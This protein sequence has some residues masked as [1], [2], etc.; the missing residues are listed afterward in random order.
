MVDHDIPGDRYKNNPALSAPAKP[1][2]W[3][4]SP[5]DQNGRYENLNHPYLPSW[6]DVFKWKFQKSP[7]RNVKDIEEWNPTV[8]ENSAWLSGDDD[9]MVWL[10]HSTFYIRLNG[11]RLITDPVFYNILSVKRK[12]RIP[13]DPDLLSG[14]DYILLSHDHRDHLDERS[15]KLV[16]KNNPDVTYLAGLSMQN[17][18]KEFTASEKIQEAGWYQRYSIQEELKI[19]FIPSRHWSKR[20]IFDTNSRLWG[21]FVLEKAGLRLLFGGDSGYDTHYGQLGAVFGEFDYAILGVGAYEP[22]WFMHPNHQSP[23]EA[24]QGFKDLR[25]KRFIP[26]HYGTFDLSDEP[27]GQPL[28]DLGDA[29]IKLSLTGKMEV[30][31]I[32]EPLLLKKQESKV[33]QL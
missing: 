1:D 8:A 14:L 22:K 30:L 17:I 26:M 20:G 7:F 11:V 24:L 31:T 9:L 15:L 27:M 12:S 19:T 10:G 28:K 3:Q 33:D 18:I 2:G 13:V 25:A 21:G 6:L 5:T 29:A 4:G 23:E 16:A 32:G